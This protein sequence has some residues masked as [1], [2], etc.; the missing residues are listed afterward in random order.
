[1][2]QASILVIAAIYCS[3]NLIADLLYAFFNPRIRYG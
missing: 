3:A 2:I 1:M